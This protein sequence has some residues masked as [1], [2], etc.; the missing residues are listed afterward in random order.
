MKKTKFFIM[1]AFCMLS[2]SLFVLT[3]QESSE[4]EFPPPPPDGAEMDE[5]FKPGKGK[6]PD[7]FG[8]VADEKEPELKAVKLL[9]DKE[10]ISKAK[11]ASKSKDESVVL[12][13]DGISA[14]L[15]DSELIKKSGDTSN[16]GQSNFYGL[17]A[18]VV[19]KG[20]SSLELKN[21]K[22]KTNADGSNAVFS[23]GEKSL[24]KID[25]IEI[26]TENNSSRGLDATYGGTIE[27]KNVKISTKGAHCAA[28]AT[29]RG[30]GTVKVDNGTAETAGEGS[31]VIYST[32]NISVC[33]LTG[34]STGSEIAVIEGKNSILI[35][36][37]E[38]SGG[39]KSRRETGCA[40][41]LYQSMS[42]DAG[43]GTSVFT[44][45]N[46]RL[47][48]NSDGA[49]FYVTNTSAKVNLKNTDIVNPTELLLQVSKN[50]S[51][52]G[53]GR[54]GANGGTLEFN[55]ENQKLSG[56]I[57]VDSISKADLNFNAGTEFKGSI[58]SEKAGKVNLNIS[59][60]AVVELTDNSYVNILSDEAADFSNI[61]SNGYT[62]F[63]NKNAEENKALG[64]KVIN[65]KDGG[66]IIGIE[67]TFEE[68]KAEEGK[69][70]GRPG[71]PPAGKGPS[72]K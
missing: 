60:K 30:E 18:A 62:L 66:K 4:N 70:P 22:I 12:A 53:W 71:K 54:K 14:S 68:P 51:E 19:S 28:F 46:S 5:N 45:E 37:S 32:G 9:S 16:G 57:I 36:D 48:S 1:T 13:S 10:N 34:K 56:K 40:V 69:K 35:Q 38:I 49:F 39:T 21:V 58:N 43:Q 47:I 50:N 42:G 41:M 33:N 61:K 67:M 44:S 24:I 63:Y 23:T 72:K 52:R 15:T 31:P 2:T 17:N 3:A 6:G 29:D 20:G 64:N 65:L 8:T 25:G 11:L 26:V 59:K 7:G 55:S 27:A